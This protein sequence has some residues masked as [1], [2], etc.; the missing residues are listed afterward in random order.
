AFGHARQDRVVHVQRAVQVDRDDL[1]PQREV[2]L[3]ERHRAVPAG[4]VD[5]H[6]DRAGGRG[7]LR[8]RVGDLAGLADVDAVRPGAPAGGG[9]GVAGV[10]AAGRVQVEDADP[11]AFVGESYRDG[12]P[13]AAAGAGDDRDLAR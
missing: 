1:L 2:G 12:A 9:D 6:V 13:D 3:Q 10:G 7:E 11:A 8:E 4:V 5:Q